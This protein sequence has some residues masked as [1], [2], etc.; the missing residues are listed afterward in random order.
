MVN[1][2]AT[3][4]C[5]SHG[6][7]TLDARN[8]VRVVGNAEEAHLETAPQSSLKSDPCFKP[9]RVEGQVSINPLTGETT[10]VSPQLSEESIR[11]IELEFRR[12][13]LDA[14]LVEPEKGRRYKIGYSYVA[15]DKTSAERLSAICGHGTKIEIS[16]GVEVIH[17]TSRWALWSDY[18]LTTSIGLPQWATKIKNISDAAES[19][20]SLYEGADGAHLPGTIEQV[21]KVKEIVS[22]TVEHVKIS[23]SR[24]YAPP[25]L[26]G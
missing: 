1:H 24:I 16:E 21:S 17:S 12:A 10:I 7:G 25:E 6:M 15:L 5:P 3:R 23:G 14:R 11:V 19:I 18:R 13:L 2:V 22:E 9:Q 20:F 26:S 4:G 8:W